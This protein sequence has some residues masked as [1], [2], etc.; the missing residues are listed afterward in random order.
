M[1][2]FKYHDLYIGQLLAYHTPPE[3]PQI[4]FMGTIDVQLAVSRDGI[5]WQ[6]AGDRKTVHPERPAGKPR[7]GRDLHG[8]RPRHR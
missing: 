5:D 7:R 8:A 6:R 4:R 2:V 1:P 3:E